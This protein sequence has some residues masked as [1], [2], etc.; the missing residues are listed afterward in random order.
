MSIIQLYILITWYKYVRYAIKFRWHAHHLSFMYV[1]KLLYGVVTF[2][3][4]HNTCQ[5]YMPIFKYVS[6]LAP[7][8][9]W[10]TANK[11]LTCIHVKI[12]KVIFP[13]QTHAAHC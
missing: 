6:V 7:A 5:V 3:F 10:H 1:L 4:V 2:I 11:W 8:L 13:S 9:S 12:N